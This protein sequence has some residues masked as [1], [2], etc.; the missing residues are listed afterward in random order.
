MISLVRRLVRDRRGNTLVIVAATLPLLVGSAGLATDTIQWALWKRQLQRA[1]DSAAIAGVYDRI[2][3]GSTSTVSTAVDR[4][5]AIN[6]HTG[7]SLA[8]SYPQIS[9][10][11]DSGTMTTQV[12]V[13]L[14]VQRKLSFSGMFMSNPPLIK[15]EATAASVPGSDDYCVISLENT[16][17]MGIQGSGSGTVEMD[18]GLI[19]NSTSSNSAAAQ[20]SSIIK[21]TVIASAG[22]I[23]HSN[24]WQVDKYDPFVPQIEDPYKDVTP[25]PSD[26]KCA[27]STS[28]S[29]KGE[30]TT[31]PL[32][33]TED[34]DLS[35]AV[36]A[37]G[38]PANC[39]ESLSVGSGK[40]L[41]LPS[42]TYYING[43]GA[44]I[45]GTLNATN[46]TTIV[47]TNKSTSTSATIGTF[48]MNA[49]GSLNITAPT[50]GEYKGI[51]IYQD[52]R[53]T[54][55]GGS[56]NNMPAS[57]PN[58]I[59]GGSSGGV[60]GVLYFP[61][62]QVT[63]NGGSGTTAKCTQFVTRRIQFSGNNTTKIKKDCSGAGIDPVQAG[64][65]VRLV[66]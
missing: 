19:T 14:A 16:N 54:D 57:A 64:R 47:L 22:G 53:A 41:T 24:N 35:T 7:M 3:T 13:V 58:K 61:S 50:S 43:G 9:F 18:C 1:A 27:V 55:S 39:F 46:G 28:V 60:T 15:T 66:G 12:K 62:Q 31:T 48:D 2:Q 52:R 42:G 49:Q 56:A 23:A 37:N 5:L 40:T 63:F 34:T 26:M 36:D 51:A 38:D 29:K 59:N 30:V 17:A 44:N 21:A 33:L 45:Q 65:R 4:D 10:P 6:Q 8:S 11:G 20:G 25:N 32:A